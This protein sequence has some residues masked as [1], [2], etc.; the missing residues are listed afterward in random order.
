LR[1]DFAEFE[2]RNAAIVA[3][4]PH[5]LEDTRETA[6]ELLL[7]FPLLADETRSVFSTYDVQ[8]KIWSM[9]QRP[10]VFLIDPLGMVRWG[11]RGTQQW[12]IPENADVLAALDT[13][14]ASD[15]KAI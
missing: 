3:L 15:Q 6:E 1:D 9:G 8:S 2:R 5:N 12:D 11:Y 10:A 14:I 13:F 7:P 4:A